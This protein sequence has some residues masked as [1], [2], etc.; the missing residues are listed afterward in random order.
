VEAGL[1]EAQATSSQKYVAKGWALRGKIVATLGDNDAAGAG[2]QRAVALAEQLQ[3]PSLLY[4]IASDLG[5]WYE[6]GGQEQQAAAL[7]GKAKAAIERMATA[8]EDEALRSVF[9]QSVLVQAVTE[10]FARTR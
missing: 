8:V 7:Y 9:L 6:A 3:S 5:Q 10:S 4:P 2:L 1:Q